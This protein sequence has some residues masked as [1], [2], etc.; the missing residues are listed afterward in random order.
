MSPKKKA[1]EL[2]LKF[3]KHADKKARPSSIGNLAMSQG[4]SIGGLLS[5]QSG[6]TYNTKDLLQSAKD[7]SVIA[8]EE[9]I[10]ECT[11]NLSISEWSNQDKKLT[12][13]EFWS[14]VLSEIKAVSV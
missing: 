4:A 7:C 13:G 9:V 11:D 1:E 3:M 5:N 12:V 10:K 2:V 8:V 6:I 14:A